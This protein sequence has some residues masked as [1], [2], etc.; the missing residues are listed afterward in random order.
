MRSVFLPD[1]FAAEEVSGGWDLPMVALALVIW[2]IIGAVLVLTTF[3]WQRR[4]ER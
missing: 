4:G 2:C 3:R 1:T